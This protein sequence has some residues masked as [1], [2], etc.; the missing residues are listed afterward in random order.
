MEELMQL[1]LEYVWKFRSVMFAIDKLRRWFDRGRSLEVATPESRAEY[2]L[3]LGNIIPCRIR[4]ML[5]L[6]HHNALACSEAELFALAQYSNRST[7]R[8]A[9]LKK[10]NDEGLI[11]YQRESDIIALTKQGRQ[12]VE[13]RLLRAS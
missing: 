8:T 12:Y 3:S 9:V 11:R 2:L 4:T 5:N 6:Y 13:R 7:F 10:L 1:L